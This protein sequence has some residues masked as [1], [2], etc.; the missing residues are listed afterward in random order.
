MDGSN[1]VLGDMTFHRF[2]GVEGIDH[3]NNSAPM[4]YSV[5]QVWGAQ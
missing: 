1:F 5:Q 4:N 2:G 3:I